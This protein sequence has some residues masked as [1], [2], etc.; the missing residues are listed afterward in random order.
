MPE[1]GGTIRVFVVDDSF[2]FRRV[3]T[4]LLQEETGFQVVGDAKDGIEALEKIRSLRPDVVIMDVEMPRLNGLETLKRLLK[5]FPVPVIM[6]SAHTARGTQTALEA[7]ALGAV[8]CLA[9]PSGSST[10]GIVKMKEELCEKIK[11]AAHCALPALSPSPLQ[12]VDIFASGRRFLE[13]LG[14]KTRR[15]EIPAV[16]LVGL[17]SSTGGPKTLVE[18]LSALKPS[19]PAAFL[20]VQ[21]M[22][23][24]FTKALAVRLNRTGVLEV[25]EAVE[26]EVLLEG[27]GYV[28]PTGRHLQVDGVPGDYRVVFHDGPPRNGVKPAADVLFESLAAKAG[29]RAAGIVL[30][31]MGKDG[32]A[33]LSRLRQ[34]G[35]WTAVQ[36]EA[37]CVVYGMPKAAFS[38]GAAVFQGTVFDIAQELHKW[39]EQP[40]TH[41]SRGKHG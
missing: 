3:L 21:H 5:E 13:R 40:T 6:F 20:F 30:T 18:L 38:R 17:A 11:A 15:E 29:A 33:G 36:D 19:L 4:K 27:R 24:G 25:E 26:G 2:F 41:P 31:G 39:L 7:L 1:D 9:K 10:F 28:A 32:A 23:A 16:H 14:V 12:A 22:S 37:S 35:G 8:E 34:A